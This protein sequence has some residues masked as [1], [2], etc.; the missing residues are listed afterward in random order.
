MKNVL[1]KIVVRKCELIIEEENVTEILKIIFRL[2]KGTVKIDECGWE[3]KPSKWT[4]QFYV[5]EEVWDEIKMKLRNGNFKEIQ[6]V[7]KDSFGNERF[8]NI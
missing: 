5:T 1:R 3:D 6:E 2:T 4:V 8:Q 7:L